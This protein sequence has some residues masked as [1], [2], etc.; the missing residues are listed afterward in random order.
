MNCL[1]PPKRWDRRFES[2]LRHGCL[3]LFCVCADLCA[4]RRADLSARS[5]TDCVK[6]QET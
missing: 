4:L 2:H 1:P 5:P 6:D 3:R